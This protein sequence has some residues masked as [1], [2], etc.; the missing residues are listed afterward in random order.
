M[1]FRGTNISVAS[2][3]SAMV[4]PRDCRSISRETASCGY[5]KSLCKYEYVFCVLIR[6]CL[7]P[8][9]ASIANGNR[10]KKHRNSSSIV[11]IFSSVSLEKNM[12]L[13]IYRLIGTTVY[14]STKHRAN[15]CLRIYELY[16]YKSNNRCR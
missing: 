2:F 10:R 4:L 3:Y 7:A 1:D 12:E 13:V 6:K 14:F 5:W 16:Y 11:N 9:D 8:V 15:R